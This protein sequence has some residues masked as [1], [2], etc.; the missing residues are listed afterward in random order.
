M[1]DLGCGNGKYLGERNDGKTRF[2]V[3]A[4]YSHNLLVI[5]TQ[6]GHQAV[7]L[8]TLVSRKNLMTCVSTQMRLDGRSFPR[9]HCLWPALHRSI[10]SS[11][12]RGTKGK[13]CSPHSMGLK[14]RRWLLCKKWA[15]FFVWGGGPLCTCGPRT[16]RKRKCP[17]T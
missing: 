11:R 3:G 10:T 12:F 2:E 4:D 8:A 7:R 16:R 13:F 17:P 14:Q 9:Q 1:L 6:R 5:V 15:V